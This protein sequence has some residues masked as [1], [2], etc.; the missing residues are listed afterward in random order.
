MSN[1]KKLAILIS[2]ISLIIIGSIATIVVVLV[3]SNQVANSNVI[4]KYSASGVACELSATYYHDQAIGKRNMTVNGSKDTNA[5][6]V[7]KFNLGTSD[8]VLSPPEEDIKLTKDNNGCYI[9]SLNSNWDEPILRYQYQIYTYLYLILPY[10][11]K[12]Q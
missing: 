9:K 11:L 2:I 1:T 4:V 6:T 10:F 12:H 5:E 7:I 8:G 3:N